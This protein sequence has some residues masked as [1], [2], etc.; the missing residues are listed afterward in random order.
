MDIYKSLPPAPPCCSAH[1]TAAL[2]WQ[3]LFT[4]SEP[5]MCIP[6]M[7][8]IVA[9][10]SHIAAWHAV[11]ILLNDVLTAE[12]PYCLH[13]KPA[14]SCACRPSPSCSGAT[15]KCWSPSSTQATL[16]CCKLWHC[17]RK[18]AASP[19]QTSWAQNKHPVYRCSCVPFASIKAE[20][21][22]CEQQGF[23]ICEKQESASVNSRGVYLIKAGSAMGQ[24]AKAS[25]LAC[26]QIQLGSD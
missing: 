10:T 8:R 14:C 18:I 17:P 4:D 5:L 11:A 25:P 20:V 26:C 21:C 3:S 12:T 22:S 23:C 19:A 13:R 16:C 15:L 2:K 7:Q 9:F 1:R 6:T 24:A